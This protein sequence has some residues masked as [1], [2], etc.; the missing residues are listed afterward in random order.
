MFQL[1]YVMTINDFINIGRLQSKMPK[2]LNKKKRTIDLCA[3]LLEKY[4]HPYL[5]ISGG[6]DS[7]AMAY[8][9]GEAA[10][11]SGKKI[12]LWSHVS[13]ASFP[14]TIETCKKVAEDIRQPLDIYQCPFSAFDVVDSERRR[15][16]GKTGVF[17]GSIREY[18]KDKDLSFVGVRADESKRRKKAALVHGQVFYSKSMGDVTVCHPV[19][20]FT[21]YDIAAT[22]YEY[23]API[24][25]IYYKTS[26]DFGKNSQGEEQ[27]IR[28]SY[29]T[30]KD[31]I[32]KGTAVFLKLNYPE[33]YA[34]LYESYPE[35]GRWT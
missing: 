35:I 15:P 26:I 25:P 6:K 17:F 21:L 7:V 13:D 30:S 5:S 9:V 34:K 8:I 14:G 33:Q 18:A 22:L 2:Y 1:R 10:E 20:W 29:I 27:F 32:N 16:F 24:H 12:Q 11:L 31:L 28:L 23:N 4:K 3:D 19:L